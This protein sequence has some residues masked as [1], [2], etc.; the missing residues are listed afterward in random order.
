MTDILLMIS[1]PLL[2]CLYAAIGVYAIHLNDRLK[3]TEKALDR[4][5]FEHLHCE[6]EIQPLLGA[7]YPSE[8]K[9]TAKKKK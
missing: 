4:A 9:P 8:E 5:R 7:I 3:A 2:I 1:V 6:A